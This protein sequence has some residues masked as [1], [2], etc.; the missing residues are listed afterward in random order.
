[1]R[2]EYVPP[3]EADI[4]G[5]DALIVAVPPDASVSAAEWTPL[6]RMLEA[7]ASQGQVRGKVAAVVGGGDAAADLAFASTLEH[8]GFVMVPV[9]AVAA[10]AGAPGSLSHARAHGRLVAETSRTRKSG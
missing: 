2:K 1:M 6:T 10:E 4:V 8:L 7:L 9:D 3:T 5:A